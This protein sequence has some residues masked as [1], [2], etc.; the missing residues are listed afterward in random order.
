MFFLQMILKILENPSYSHQPEK[1]P[2]LVLV[3][4]QDLLP[5]LTT[6]FGEFPYLRQVSEI[7]TLHPAAIPESN[8]PRAVLEKGQLEHTH[9]LWVF[10]E[11]HL[12]P[13][14]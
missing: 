8:E 12:A 3:F 10:P 14:M 4:K 2:S 6:S 13:T 7:S 11:F 1:C 5:V 9:F